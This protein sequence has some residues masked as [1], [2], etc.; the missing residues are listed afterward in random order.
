MA[1][2]RVL[3]ENLR[4]HGAKLGRKHRRALP[5]EW[6]LISPILNID[7]VQPNES[8]KQELKEPNF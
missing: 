8:Q 3:L 1:V 5:Q 2:V 6:E 7:L 4:I